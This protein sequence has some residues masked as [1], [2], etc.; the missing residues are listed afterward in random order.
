MARAEQIGRLE[1]IEAELEFL[2]TGKQSL[3]VPLNAAQGQP[4]GS[5]PQ[6]Q[7]AVG[8]AGDMAELS[9]LSRREIY[10]A[11]QWRRFRQLSA[12]YHT[13][14]QLCSLCEQR[15]GDTMHYKRQ[16]A[17]IEGAISQLNLTEPDPVRRPPLTGQTRTQ[18]LLKT[19]VGQ[20]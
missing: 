19:A 2:R 7:P 16:L 3:T 5:A 15:G 8:A 20:R 13:L 4:D 17:E 18:S 12:E 11:G 10:F 9:G 6:A 1:Q 14:S